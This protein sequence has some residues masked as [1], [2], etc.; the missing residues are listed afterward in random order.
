MTS[1]KYNIPRLQWAGTPY[2]VGL[3]HGEQLAPQILDQLA[4][5]RAM[6]AETCNFDWA[7][8]RETAE[9]FRATIAHLAPALLDEMRGIADGVAR[10]YK[11]GAWDGPV[12]AVDIVALN[13]RSEI[14]LGQWDDGCT[15]VAWR[16]DGSRQLLAQNWDWRETVGK[17]LAMASI[18]APGKPRMWMVIEPGIVGKIGFNA[19]SVGVCLNA[20]RA[21][22]IST[23]LL[24]VHL[25]LRLALESTSAE[26]AIRTFERLGGCASSQHILI[27]DAAGAHGLELSPNGAEYLK[28][29][30]DGLLAH[31]NHFLANTLVDEP[32]WLEGSRPRLARAYELCRALRDE[33]GAEKLPGTVDG[34]LLRGRVFA[35]THGGPQAICGRADPARAAAIQTLFNIAMDLGPG[36]APTAEVVFGRPGSGEESSVFCMPW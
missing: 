3:Q 7:R 2:E 8:V 29:D 27:A 22:P 1:E 21:R 17:N 24:P 13:A 5:Y 11:T 9:E 31:T 12:D 30:A 23:S 25:L 34:A 4:I 36:H 26:G 14:A 6:F 33:L 28:P 20:I 32:P 18:T 35:D 19:A 16:V 15:S 10:G